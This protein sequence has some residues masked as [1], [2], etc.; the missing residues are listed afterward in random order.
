MIDVHGQ[1]IYVGKAKRLK[2]RVQSYFRKNVN[3]TN[4]VKRMIPAIKSIEVEL[5]DTEL[6]ALLRER[7]LIHELRP[8][9]NK[10]MNKYERYRY[11]TIRNAKNVT[12]EQ[13]P[14]P[15]EFSI[16]AFRNRQLLQEVENILNDTYD[17][18]FHP[19]S[20]YQIKSIATSGL[21]KEVKFSEIWSLFNG[22]SKL[23]IHRIEANRDLAAIRLHFE[24]AQEYQKA[25]ET[26]NY[27]TSLTKEKP[28]LVFFILDIDEKWEKHYMIYGGTVLKTRKVT[29]RTSKKYTAVE[30][31]EK[32]KPSTLPKFHS[33][34]QRED[35][36]QL[37]IVESYLRTHKEVLRIE[38]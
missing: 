9:N 5:V 11:F 2:T 16:G 12:I 18:V 22:D 8:V 27:F 29:K 34:I 32:L 17:L 14:E 3:H 15:E 13:T 23:V 36:D 7:E 24:E 28:K 1:V 35:V 21:A 38:L 6:D 4:K 19:S 33:L 26:I 31:A 37:A 10:Q 30:L 25:I 20:W